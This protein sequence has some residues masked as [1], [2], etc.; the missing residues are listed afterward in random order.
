MNSLHIAPVQGHTDAAWRHFH[1]EVYGGDA[2]YYTP[3]I[4]AEHGDLR[5]RDL[6]DFS[7]PLNEGLNLE[8]QVIFRDGAELSILL[9][10]LAAE[11]ASRINLNMGCPFPLQM[12]KGRGCGF[13]SNT[14]ELGN[15][16]SILARHPELS[17]SLKM[18]LG[19]E[20]PDEWRGAIDALR[21]IP[22][23]FVAM[24]PRTGRQQYAGDLNLDAFR[25]L[26]DEAPWPVVYNGEL[27]TPDDIARVASEFPGID[28]VMAG[29][30][31]L[32]RPSLFAE[33]VAGE[34]WPREK[35]IDVMLDFHRRLFEHYRASLCGESQLLSKIKPFWEYAEQEIGRKPW[36]AI[37]KAGSMPKYLSAVA[38]IRE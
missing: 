6:R 17:F 19:M 12:G 34:E 7:G 22:L 32:A 9:S 28:G 20:K 27:H 36:K 15:I 30:G 38:L 35:R 8:P 31:V 14:Q 1:H 11:G 33:Y 37:M 2:L 3:F 10:R 4:R 18:R 24:H 23:R 25:N 13:L 16:A 21:D 26:L 5:Q 29:R